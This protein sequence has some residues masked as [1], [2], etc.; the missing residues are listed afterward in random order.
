M[1]LFAAQ[2]VDGWISRHAVP[3]D[4]FTSASDKRQFLAGLRACDACVLGRAT[5]DLV[6]RQLRPEALPGL[7]RVV[8][9]R[10]PAR[11]GTEGVPG[12]VEFTDA[13]PGVV[14][15]KLRADGRRRCAVLGGGQ[16][17]AAWLAAGLVDEVE[18][19]LEP[20]LFGHGTPLA[21]GAGAAALDVR[22]R[23]LEHRELEAGGPLWLR[24]AVERG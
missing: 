19:T 14:A 1:V 7:R 16:L 13:A 18:L 6:K 20:R 9:T 8:W 12:V 10:Q 15:A 17:N 11:F 5:Y 4:D 24:Y 3:G 22:L 23:L 21:G 2:S